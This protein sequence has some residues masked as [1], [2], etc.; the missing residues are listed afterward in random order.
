MT[1]EKFA[2][3]LKDVDLKIKFYLLGNCSERRKLLMRF[4]KF[5]RC[6]K[7]VLRKI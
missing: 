2:R 1:P 5:G 7:D 4:E 6:L 3:C